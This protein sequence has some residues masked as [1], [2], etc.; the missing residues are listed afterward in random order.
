M[1]FHQALNST[2]STSEFPIYSLFDYLFIN[3]MQFGTLV[4]FNATT[5]PKMQNFTWNGNHTPNLFQTA[6]ISLRKMARQIVEN[7]LSM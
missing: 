7:H 4:Y 3:A 1:Y 5:L 2:S 6:K